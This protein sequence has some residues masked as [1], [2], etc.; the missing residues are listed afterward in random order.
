MTTFRITGLL[1]GKSTPVAGGSPHNGPV[2]RSLPFLCC[3]AK[4]TIGQAVE[5]SVIWDAMTLMW[6]HCNDVWLLLSASATTG[7][8]PVYLSSCAS[9]LQ[10][11]F[12]RPSHYL[13][14]FQGSS[15]LARLEV[16]FIG[17]YG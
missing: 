8:E 10:L 7:W 9:L 15:Y 4:Q 16:C 13:L 2:M 1:G 17:I 5:L 14:E 6:R 3:Y 11:G 12:T